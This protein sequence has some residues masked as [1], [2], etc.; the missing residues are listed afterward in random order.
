M[1]VVLGHFEHSQ[2]FL[3]YKNSIK[4]CVLHDLTTELRP[5]YYRP[6]VERSNP[7]RLGSKTSVQLGVNVDPAYLVVYFRLGDKSLAG[8]VLLTFESG[9]Y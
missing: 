5:H 6:E 7:N 9:Y 1:G 4:A 8:D 2:Y 3:R